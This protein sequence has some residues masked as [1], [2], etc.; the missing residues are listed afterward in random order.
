M[1]G[2]ARS[3]DPEDLKA[4]FK[5]AAEIAAVVPESMQEAAFHRALDQILGA[6]A[7]GSEAT[8]G[9]TRRRPAG[10]KKSSEEARSADAA[11]QLID[12][13][14]RTGYPEIASASK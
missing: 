9:S 8:K 4:A 11:A 1:P 2:Q 14:N 5:E 6:S 13:I 7:Q 12:G 10:A 3:S